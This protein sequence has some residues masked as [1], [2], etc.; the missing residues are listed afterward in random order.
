MEGCEWMKMEL[1]PFS[2]FIQIYSVFMN[3]HNMEMIWK[4]WRWKDFCLFCKEK[5]D[6]IWMVIMFC[7]SAGDIESN[8]RYGDLGEYSIIVNM[9]TKLF[10]LELVFNLK[11]FYPQ[12]GENLNWML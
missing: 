11:G 2:I 7:L 8:A 1:C 4:I 5:R 10:V 12:F 9:K 3:I 6:S